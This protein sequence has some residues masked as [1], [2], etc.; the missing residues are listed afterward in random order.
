MHEINQIAERGPFQ[1]TWESLKQF[2]VPAWYENAKFGIFVHWGV[3]AVPAFSNEW[4]PRNM[5][6]QGTEEFQHHVATYG[7]HN[8]FGYKDFI[9]HFKA[10]R[11]DPHQWAALFRK[12][13]ARYVVPVAEHH[14]GFPM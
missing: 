10:E 9:P 2:S 7:P 13:G 8:Q 4:Y 3:Y 5:Y 6:R 11:F 12:S 14:D 1:P